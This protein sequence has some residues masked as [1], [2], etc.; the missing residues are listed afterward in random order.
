LR[1]RNQPYHGL[2]D[3]R[4]GLSFLATLKS[5]AFTCG[6]DGDFNGHYGIRTWG[7]LVKQDCARAILQFP[8]SELQ[9]LQG[10]KIHAIKFARASRWA[11]VGHPLWEFDDPV[12]ILDKA[13]DEI[14]GNPVVVDS[15]NL[16]RRPVLV[17]QAILGL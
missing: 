3:W 4:L 7:N 15:F 10:G 13:A 6:L 12:G 8:G 2:L 11:I 5:A 9:Q 1:Y 14:G 17:R 16:A